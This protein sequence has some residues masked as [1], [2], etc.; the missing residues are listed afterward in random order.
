MCANYGQPARNIQINTH[1][2]TRLKPRK[3]ETLY[4]LNFDPFAHQNS[5]PVPPQADAIV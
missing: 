1:R 5:I 4:F 3:I 2:T